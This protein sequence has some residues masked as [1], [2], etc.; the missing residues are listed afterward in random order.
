MQ[1]SIHPCFSKHANPKLVIQEVTKF[2][3]VRRDLSL[4]LDKQVSFEEIQNLIME[5]REEVD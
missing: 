4:V 2:P 5:D 1:S 3:E